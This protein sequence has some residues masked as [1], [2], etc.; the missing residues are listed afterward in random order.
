MNNLSDERW[1][2]CEKNIKLNIGERNLRL[3][4]KG[5]ARVSSRHLPLIHK[6]NETS[7]PL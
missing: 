4:E 6:V 3:N 1:P 7:S 5:D 2:L